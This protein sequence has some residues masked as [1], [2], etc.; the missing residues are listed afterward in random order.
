MRAIVIY[1]IATAGDHGPR[2]LRRIASVCE[3]YGIRVQYSVFECSLTDTLFTAF[4][5]EL[6]DVLDDQLDRVTIYRFPE[7][8]QKFRTDLGKP[9]AFGA[10]GSWII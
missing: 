5:H 1:D 8:I 6:N 9:T 2:R 10:E 3:S 7:S 4:V